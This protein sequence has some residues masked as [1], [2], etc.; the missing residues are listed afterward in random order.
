MFHNY[1]YVGLR[2]LHSS[3]DPHLL[4]PLT[5][6]SSQSHTSLVAHISKPS[7]MG[8]ESTIYSS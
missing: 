2:P 5:F 4:T 1:N 3:F 8:G 6:Q 7:S